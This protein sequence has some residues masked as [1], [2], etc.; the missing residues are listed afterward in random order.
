MKIALGVE[1]DGRQFC[2]WQIQEGNR[3]VQACVEQALSRVADHPVRTICAGRTDAKVHALGQV[4]HFETSARRSMHSWVFG[5]T[6]NL[7]ADICARWALEVPN[8]FSARYSAL[9][10]H[11]RY[12]IFN[13]RVRPAVAAHQMS[14]DYR[15]LDEH[16]MSRAAAY[17]LGEHDFSSYRAYA[18][19]S[20]SP[21]RTIYRLDVVRR[22]HYVMIDIEANAFLHHMVRNIAGV[23]LTIGA[24][25]Q[26]VAWVQEVLEQRDRKKG[27]LTAPPQG[28]YLMNVIY[29][30]EFA[31]PETD[32]ALMFRD[33]LRL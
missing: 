30:V 2:G 14:W 4:I 18:C 33:Y 3:T 29:P 17:L 6:A 31:L 23:L 16:R 12:I 32:R 27:G 11:Y 28:L 8:H 1:Y 13:K 5:A 10:R 15:P 21:V 24:G 26:P 22:E 7:P 19:Q 25:E 9:R 20:R